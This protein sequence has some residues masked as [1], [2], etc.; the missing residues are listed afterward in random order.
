MKSNVDNIENYINELT[1]ERREPMLKLHQT[2]FS[3][4]PKGFEAQMSYGMIGYVVPHHIYPNG[5]HCNPQL[6]LP[7]M[8]IASQKNGISFYH[9]GLYADENLFDWFKN[10]YL[11]NCKT[12]LDIGKSCI[13]FKKTEHIPFDLLAK[14]VKKMT[15]NDW[16]SIYEINLKK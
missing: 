3:N 9:M 15:V 10:E 14:L 1:I 13:R 8:A 5:Y 11:K 6:P 7:F 16:I 2:I 12:K 4:L